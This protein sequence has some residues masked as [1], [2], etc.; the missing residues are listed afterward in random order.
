[1]NRQQQYHQYKNNGGTMSIEEWYNDSRYDRSLDNVLL[2]NQLISEFMGAV[3]SDY[4]DYLIFKVGN[5]QYVGKINHSEIFYHSEWNWLIPVVKKI[6]Q[7]PIE[8]FSKKKPV[9]SAL[10]DVDIDSLYQSIV[11]FV[12]WYNSQGV[13]D[14]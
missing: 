3:K 14:K 6:Q 12:K 2:N 9:M 4:G 7:L 8:E 11:V 10:M 5:P 1:M 13:S